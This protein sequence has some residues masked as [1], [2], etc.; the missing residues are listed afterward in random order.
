MGVMAK[1]VIAVCYIRTDGAA[2]LKYKASPLL[3]GLTAILQ[4]VQCA[5]CSLCNPSIDVIRKIHQASIDIRPRL[6]AAGPVL[7]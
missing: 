4:L 7:G 2:V 6:G 5:V 1:R 3:A